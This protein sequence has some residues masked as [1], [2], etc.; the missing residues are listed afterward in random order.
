M[1]ERSVIAEVKYTFTRGELL[2]LG[3]EL[4]RAADDVREI[5]ARKKELTSAV[6]AELKKANGRVFT[7]AGKIRDRHEMREVTCIVHYGSPRPGM[8]LLTRQDTGEVV[9]EEPMTTEEMQEGLD[10]GPGTGPTTPTQ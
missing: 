2:E 9:R 6:T 8:K 1:A 4:A 5:E 10:F 3:D 7:L